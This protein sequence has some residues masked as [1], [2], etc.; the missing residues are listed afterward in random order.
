MD[1]MN[2]LVTSTDEKYEAAFDEIEYEYAYESLSDIKKIGGGNF[3]QV[4]KAN[5]KDLPEKRGI[6]VVAVKQM[7]GKIALSSVYFIQ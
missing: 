2:I 1:R 7:K 3:S 4:F 6:S 5:A